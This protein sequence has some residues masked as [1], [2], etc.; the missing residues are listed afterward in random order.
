MSEHLPGAASLGAEQSVERSGRCRR[1]HRTGGRGASV[2]GE[3]F[4]GR[5]GDDGD[6][7]VTELVEVIAHG[8]HVFLTRQSS[9]MPMQD[10]HE[11]SAA[12]L[13]GPPRPTLVIDELDVRERV[14]DG[15]V[16]PSRQ[17]ERP[18]GTSAALGSGD[19]VRLDLRPHGRV[20]R[21]D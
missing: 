16:M 6:P 20:V 9:E 14:T 12:H 15:S 1:Q 3:T 5:E 10:Q 17:S 18:G 11:W 21:S 2:G 7:G 8:D 4:G 13:G 19:T